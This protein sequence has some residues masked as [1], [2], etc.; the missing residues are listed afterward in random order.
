MKKFTVKD[1]EAP[2]G[3]VFKVVDL[4]EETLEKLNNIPVEEMFVT[5]ET[6][7]KITSILNLFN[8]NVD[9]LEAIRN[10]VVIGMSQAD[11][12]REEYDYDNSIRVSMITSVIDYFIR[13]KGGEV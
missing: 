3:R 4:D 8:H 2:K 12:S 9:E 11:V 7:V 10:S 6:T 13:R 5:D 1:W